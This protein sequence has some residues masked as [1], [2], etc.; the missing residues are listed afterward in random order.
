M[1]FAM[2]DAQHLVRVELLA[3]GEIVGVYTLNLA[4]LLDAVKRPDGQVLA[5]DADL[6]AGIRI[7][8]IRIRPNN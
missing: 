6:V 7:D 4:T 3:G 2:T 1:K 5:F 8:C